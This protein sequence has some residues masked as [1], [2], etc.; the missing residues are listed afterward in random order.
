MIQAVLEGK[1]L[2]YEYTEDILTSTVFCTVKYLRPEMILIPFI[3]SSFLYNE[4]RTTL[5]EKLNS[6]GIELRCYREV[7]YIFWTWNEN[8]GE[9]DLILIF[10][11]HAHGFDDLL[12]LVEAKFKSGKSGTEENDQ[13]VRYFEAINNDIE[14]FT[15]ASVSCFKGR[16]GY[17]IYLTEAE[18]YS[19]ILATTKIIQ[20][21]YNEIKENVFH[22]RWHQLYKTIEKM[23]PFYSSFEKIIAYDLMKYMEKLGLRDFSGVSLP[24]KS[25][26]SVFSLPYPIFYNDGNNTTE[27]KTYFDQLNDSNIFKEKNIFYR[28][29]QHE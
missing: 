24:G 5:W 9:P 2:G 11:D 8:Y 1:S 18:A 29:N 17:I 6:E 20:S 13:L 28:G 4:E 12:L 21:R 10:R 15:D 14:N 23:D 7:E 26:D 27:N 22:L 16:K 19:D 25:L 3:E